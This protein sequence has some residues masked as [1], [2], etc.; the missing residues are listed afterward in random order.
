MKN[1][2]SFPLP[3]P[4]GDY[5]TV[6]HE[7]FQQIPYAWSSILKKSGFKIKES[8]GTCILPW[9]L[10]EPFSTAILAKWYKQLKVF[11]TAYGHLGIFRYF[12]YLICFIAQKD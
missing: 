9:S 1:H 5:P 4:H 3:E 2:P 11:H 12:C 6:F 8:F 10:I 7:F